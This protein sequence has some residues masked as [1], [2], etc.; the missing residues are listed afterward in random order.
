MRLSCRGLQPRWSCPWMAG[1]PRCTL[2][3]GSSGKTTRWCGIPLAGSSR[4]L[5]STCWW[6]S[7][8]WTCT[9]ASL[10]SHLPRRFLLG[11]IPP[12]LIRQQSTARAPP[13]APTTDSAGGPGS[14]SPPRPRRARPS[15]SAAAPRPRIGPAVRSAQGRRLAAAS[16]SGT[17][18]PRCPKY[19]NSCN[20]H[21]SPVREG[22]SLLSI[23]QVRKS[24]CIEIKKLA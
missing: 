8:T 20:P 1:N 6:C 12:R 17:S 10:E 14:P 5:W 19:F 13:P 11:C 23:F 16:P 2:A 24:R 15:S 22:S 18:A 3:L 21:T 9:S 4:R 7:Q